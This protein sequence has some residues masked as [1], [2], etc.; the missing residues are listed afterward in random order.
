KDPTPYLYSALLKQQQNRINEA[1]RD[2]ETSQDLNK[3][4]SLYRS[5]LLLDQDS[6]VRGANLAQ[7]YD[8]AGMSDVAQREAARAI[9]SDYANYSAHYFLANSFNNLR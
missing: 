6:A 1:I 3:N 2:L 8:D 5:Q 7:I 4:R 9:N